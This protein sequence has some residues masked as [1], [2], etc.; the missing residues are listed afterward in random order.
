MYICYQNSKLVMKEFFKYTLATVVGIIIVSLIFGIL[1]VGSIV[2]MLASEESTKTVDD[3]SVFILPLS[4]SLQERS[5]EDIFSEFLGVTDNKLGLED[6]LSAIKKAKN[7]DKIKGIYIEAGMFDG[8]EPATLQTLRKALVDFRKSGKWIIS[9]ADT[10]T[11]GTYYVCSAANKVYLN[12]VGVIDWHGLSSQ[13]YFLKDML[14]KFGVKVQLAKVGAYKSAPEMLTADKMSDANREQV[15]DMINGIWSQICEDVSASRHISVKDLNDYADRL[16]TFAPQEDYLKYKMVDGLVY[17]DSIKSIIKTMLKVDKKDDIKQLTLADMANVKDENKKGDE[18]A[19]YYAYGD[20][21][22]TTPDEMSDN[23]IA[24][25]KMCKELQN[26]ADDDEVKAVVIRVNSG[27]GSAYASEQIWHSVTKLKAK[28]PVVISMGG[29]AASGAY[30]LSAPANWIVA[31]PTT[32][33]GSIGIFGLF[34]DFS[35][36]LTDKLGIKFDEVKTNKNS[37][38]GTL[39]RPFTEEEM[40]YLNSYINR[41][42]QLFRNRVA[43]GRH[44]SV[45]EIEKIAQGHVWLGKAALSNGLV[46]QLGTIDDAVL[47]AAKLAKIKEYHTYSYP[48]KTDFLTQL[49]EN[50]KHNYIDDHLHATLGEYYKPF[51]FLKSIDKQDAMQARMMFNVN[52]K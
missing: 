38:F 23:Y 11:Q 15:S 35:G 22:D 44:K 12:P 10:Y 31:E 45:N 13:P 18:V 26:L 47:K 25:D 16:I 6:I 46:D 1:G 48:A 32:L 50:K 8:G 29:M 41:G 37:S 17:T 19:V 21:V 39:A 3:N 20:V 33:T 5:S 27:G 34:P 4:G 9:Y 40:S 51:M 24:A 43:E 7:N 30:Y 36:L 14:A 42:Y 52:M 28:K 49:F 2:G